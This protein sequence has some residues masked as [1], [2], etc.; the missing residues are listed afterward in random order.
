MGKFYFIIF[1]LITITGLTAQDLEVA[2]KLSIE[3]MNQSNNSEKVVVRL[4][5]GTLALRDASTIPNKVL[6]VT[7]YDT[8]YQVLT[9][10]NDTIFLENGG[11]VKLPP[12]KKDAHYIGE[13]YGGGVIFWLDESGDHGLICDIFDFREYQWF[14]GVGGE[15]AT[16]A[17]GD[18]IGAGEMNTAIIISRQTKDL[19]T[20]N[21]AALRCANLVRNS[22]GDWY[23]PS[24]EELNLI[25]ENREII[26]S[27]ALANGGEALISDYS[28]PLLLPYYWSSTEFDWFDAWG[29]DFE[30]GL[31]FNNHKGFAHH[32]RAIRAF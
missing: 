31:P 20:G 11:F 4:D 6:Q 22:Y 13:F 30:S 5:D 32:V 28:N 7:I 9:I 3:V 21:F 16:N 15:I 24:K 10:S 1:S 27:T 26:D 23:L 19:E 25:Y 29:Q 2:G 14:L 12:V 17:R 8:V 18:G